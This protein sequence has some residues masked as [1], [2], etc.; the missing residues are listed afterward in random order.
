LAIDFRGGGIIKRG[1]RGSI[2]L[3]EDKS[4]MQRRGQG[5]IDVGSASTIGESGST[6]ECR[7]GKGKGRTGKTPIGIETIER[8]TPKMDWGP[9][10][11]SASKA[12][13]MAE[14]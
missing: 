2:A 7:L 11:G 12:C 13:T 4:F 8:K 5:H 10:R 14:A 6:P 3:L 9:S 1:E